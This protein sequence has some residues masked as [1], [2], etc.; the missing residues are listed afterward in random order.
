MND[1]GALQK[2]QQK[3]FILVGLNFLM[4]VVLF[5]GLGYVTWQSAV[6]V[7]RLQTDLEKAEHTIAQL[8]IQLQQIDAESIVERVVTNTTEQIKNSMQK[9]TQDFDIAYHITQVSE[10]LDATQKTIEETNQAIIG[11]NETV[12]GLSDKEISRYVSYYLLKDL[13]E[14]LQEA[15]EKNKPD[16]SAID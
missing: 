5:T 16:Q 9:V 8:K 11:V 13:G 15:A 14:G 10:K 7:N 1:F 12:Q 4:F 2:K 3:I 6:L